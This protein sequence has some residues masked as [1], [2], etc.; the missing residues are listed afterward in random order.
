MSSERHGRRDL[1]WLTVTEY[2][3][4]NSKLNKMTIKYRQGIHKSK[5]ATVRHQGRTLTDGFIT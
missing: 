2:L 3:F 1:L 4:M 5:Y